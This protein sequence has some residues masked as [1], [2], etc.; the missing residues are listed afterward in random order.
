MAIL[1]SSRVG[2]QN[3]FSLI[4]QSN[5]CDNAGRAKGRAT[6]KIWSKYSTNDRGSLAC[7]FFRFVSW[8]QI[9]RCRPDFRVCLLNMG[10]NERMRDSLFFVQTKSIYLHPTFTKHGFYFHCRFQ[11]VFVVIKNINYEHGI[12]NQGRLVGHTDLQPSTC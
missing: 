12:L 7:Y 1:T 10:W 5:V 11:L 8:P 2:N 9:Q 6:E 4:W 3:N